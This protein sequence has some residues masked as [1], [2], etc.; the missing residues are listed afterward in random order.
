MR[1]YCLLFPALF[2]LLSCSHTYYIVRHAEKAV[3]PGASNMQAQDPPLTD[4]GHK[5]AVALKDVLGDKNIRYIFSTNTI[6]TKSTA[7]PLREQL[8]LE[9]ATYARADS[10][11]IASLKKLKKNTLVVGHSNTV[12]ELVNGLYNQK[13]LSDLDDAE[14]DNLFE[15]VYK[16]K[17]FGSAI[18]YH[19]KRYGAPAHKE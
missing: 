11:F 2:L 4:T 7:E 17:L 6:R 12:D 10:A 19:R 5:R 1:I 15:V 18:K 13:V 14:Y 3:M 9:I 16:K 8:Q